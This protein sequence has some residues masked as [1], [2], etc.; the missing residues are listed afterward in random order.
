MHDNSAMSQ[1]DPVHPTHGDLPDGGSRAEAPVPQG[2]TYVSAASPTSVSAAP[3]HAIGAWTGSAPPDRGAATSPAST[4]FMDWRGRAGSSWR[5]FGI[6]AGTLASLGAAGG[7][8][9]AYS[10]WRHERN[11]R[12]NRV[13]RRVRAVAKAAGGRLPDRSDITDRMPD[14]AVARPLGGGSVALLFA[15]LLVNRIV[16]GRRAHDADAGGSPGDQDRGNGYRSDS[17]RALQTR[18]GTLRLPESLDAGKARQAG[19]S[20]LVAA[21]DRAADL[22]MPS[23]SRSIGLGGVLGA[24]AA[25]YLLWRALN[26]RDDLHQGWH[27]QAVGGS[28]VPR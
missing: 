28:E 27:P 22:Q 4:S 5:V 12:I 17:F 25:L 14:A 13:R 3:S 1:T 7:A 6:G 9:W 26:P 24:G 23:R 2:S 19:E 16:G 8:L 20:L 18:W 21:R 15:A 11:R 10:R